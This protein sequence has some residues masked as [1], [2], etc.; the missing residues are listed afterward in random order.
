MRSTLISATLALCLSPT[1]Y[2]APAVETAHAGSKP[3]TQ[4]TATRNAAVLAQLPFADKSDY[5]WV[6]RGLVAPF[7]GRINDARGNVI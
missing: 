4:L 3:A 1:V 6:R 5:E 2:A 7:A